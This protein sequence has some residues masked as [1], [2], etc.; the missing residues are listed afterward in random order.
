MKVVKVWC[1]YDID[2]AEKVYTDIDLAKYYVKEEFDRRDYGFSDE[3][4]EELQEDC[5]LTFE[6]VEVVGA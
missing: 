6:W 2:A 3:E 4:F 5:Y 1:E